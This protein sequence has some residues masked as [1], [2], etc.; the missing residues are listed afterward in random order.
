MRRAVTRKKVPRKLE[1]D[2]SD[3]KTGGWRNVDKNDT[4]GKVGDHRW[5]FG[6]INVIGRGIGKLED[7]SA[8]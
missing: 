2:R 6:C 3:V 5:R 1:A 8:V 4:I 7:M